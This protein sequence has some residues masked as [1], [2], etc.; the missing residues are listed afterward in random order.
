MSSPTQKIGVWGEDQACQFLIR[1]GFIL[2][3][4]NYHSTQGEIDIVAKKFDDYYFIE[5][6]TRRVGPFATDLSIT[7]RKKQKFLKTIRHYCYHKKINPE[8]S[9]ITAGLLVI[10]SAHLKQ[11]R[12]RLAVIY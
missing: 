4:R 10:V 2:L 5:V 12:F 6:K 11:V 3:D 9:L 7:Y 8:G 1:N